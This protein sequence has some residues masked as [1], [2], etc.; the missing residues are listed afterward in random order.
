MRSTVPLLYC[1]RLAAPGFLFSE[2]WSIRAMEHW[3][4]Q[5]S[6][7]A[8][9]RSI[10]RLLYCSRFSV[11]GLF[12]CQSI[13]PVEQWING[14]M[15]SIDL[16]FHCS[17]SPPGFLHFQSIGAMDNRALVHSANGIYCSIDLLLPSS[18]FCVPR[19]FLFSEHWSIGE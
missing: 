18:C 11:P 1:S 17:R 15:R 14:P 13:G 3:L 8:T 5:A 19:G 12:Y 6:L 16:L 2:H 10:V 7:N 4:L 9:M